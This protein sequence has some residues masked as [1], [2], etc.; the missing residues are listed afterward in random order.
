MNRILH[1]V[2]SFL[3]LL[4]TPVGTNVQT[5]VFHFSDDV[6]IVSIYTSAQDLNPVIVR[7]TKG[8]ERS[9]VRSSKKTSQLQRLCLDGD[10]LSDSS[11]LSFCSK[12]SVR[13]ACISR[14]LLIPKS[15]KT[16]F[17]LQTV[18]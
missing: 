4:S 12:E 6:K 3:I 8:Q 13:C 1:I 7:Q 17:F 9:F 5:A 15:L 11:N 18:I 2:I 16:V 10:L 14:I